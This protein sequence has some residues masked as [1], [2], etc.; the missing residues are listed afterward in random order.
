M[1]RPNGTGRRVQ[2]QARPLREQYAQQRYQRGKREETPGTSNRRTVVQMVVCA[3]L[4]A[5]IVGVKLTAPATLETYRDRVLQLVN[6][7]TD[8]VAAFSAVGRAIGSE[9]LGEALNDT[10]VAVFGADPEPAAPVMSAATDTS[11]AFV[12][13]EDNTPPRARMMQQVLGFAYIPP[14]QGEITSCFGYRTHPLQQTERFHYGLDIAAE[15]G[16]VIGAFADGTV[17]AVG[18]SSDLGKYVELQHAGGFSTLYA[19]CSTVTASSGQTVQM[20]DPIA[21][22]G[23]TGE[24]TGPHLHFELHRDAIALNPIYYV[25]G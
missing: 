9:K 6:H 20:G 21:E 24:T 11:L 5:V 8:F 1:G 10:Y 14:L 2:S 23:Q 15:T 25:A 18:E 7:D 19:H 13:T 4:L 16:T 3:L 22:V 17:T 12:Y